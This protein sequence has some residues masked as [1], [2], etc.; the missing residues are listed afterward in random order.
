MKKQIIVGLIHEL[1]MGGAE[2][3]MVNILNHFV[4]SNQEVHLI[5]FKNI[6]SLKS[7]L[8]SKILIHDLKVNSVSKGIFSCLK[9]IYKIK[10]NVVF[11]GIGHL[12]L[13]VSPFIPIMK[14]LLPQTRWIARETNIVSMQNQNAKSTRLFN[15]LYRN[16]YHHYDAIV[17]QST[18]MLEDLIKHYPQTEAK[19]VLIHNPIDIERV[20]ALA[21]EKEIAK[22]ELITV[23]TLT[24]RKRQAL[25]I[26]VFSQLPQHYTLTIVGSGEEEKNLKKL[27]KQLDLGERVSLVG[28]Q[29]N[30]YPYLQSA[31]IFVLTSEHEGF[32][33]VLL[34]ANALGIPV[35]AFACLGG[36]NEI[37]EEDV[38][39]FMVEN[40]NKE[41]LKTT[42]LKASIYNF[43]REKIIAQTQERYSC[44]K[45][46]KKYEN[47]FMGV[48][49][50]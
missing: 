46:M 42:I 35:V 17:T 41:E 12:N 47:L 49:Y 20:Q 38:N 1:T 10:P 16:F 19:V 28:H 26:E 39:G 36:I 4:K 45:I 5:V 44:Q 9:T 43:D 2:R 8:D 50:V 48:D 18:D 32:P 6:G 34:E 14:K 11:S 29:S 3:M 15:W 7:L 21:K 24:P 27:L 33:N 25:L 30:P 13:S 40:G 37:I 23:G 22:V 31:K